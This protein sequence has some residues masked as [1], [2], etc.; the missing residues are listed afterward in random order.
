MLVMSHSVT[1]AMEGIAPNMI[2]IA[3]GVLMDL[4]SISVY[5][6]SVEDVV[7][8]GVSLIM[9]TIQVYSLDIPQNWD[10]TSRDFIQKFRVL[11]YW[12]LLGDLAMKGD[13][14]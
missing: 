2:T 14:S 8:L 6:V 1:C 11:G 9:L 4:G 12:D 5:L 7:I 13:A 3:S 10:F